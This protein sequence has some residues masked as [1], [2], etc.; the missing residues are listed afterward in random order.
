MKTIQF[1]LANG[2]SALSELFRSLQGE[3]SPS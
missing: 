2:P 3:A 1:R